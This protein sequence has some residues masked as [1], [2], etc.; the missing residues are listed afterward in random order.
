MAEVRSEEDV[1]N[2]DSPKLGS[3]KND[4]SVCAGPVKSFGAQLM[5]VAVSP[6][7]VAAPLGPADDD[8]EE[9]CCGCC[10]C[11]CCKSCCAAFCLASLRA[12][13]AVFGILPLFFRG[14]R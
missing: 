1:D 6:F 14:F 11:C 13:V 4:V 12:K 2:V 7:V 3:D 8:E 5:S 10:A 9:S